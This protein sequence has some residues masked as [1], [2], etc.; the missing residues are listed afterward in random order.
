MASNRNIRNISAVFKKYV[1]MDISNSDVRVI[2]VRGNQVRKWMTSPLPEGAV[3]DGMIIE[4]HTVSVIIDNVF[5]SLNLNKNNVLCSL[6][7]LPFIY[8]VISMPRDEHAISDEAIERAARQEMS[9]AQEDIH[10]LWQA[11]E[12]NP[13]NMEMDYF[14]LGVPRNYIKPLEDTIY[15][16]GIKPYIVDVKPLA[17]ARAAS[18]RDGLIVS[19]EKS[20]YDIVLVSNGLVRVMHSFS[21]GS[22]PVDK[23]S[24]VNDVIDGLNKA[25]KSFN[26]DFPENTLDPDIPLLLAGETAADSEIVA[27]MQEATGHPV[28]ILNPVLEVPAEMPREIYSAA[29]GLV[30]KKIKP[31]V[32]NLQYRDIDINLLMKSKKGS[33]LRYQLAY[34]GLGVF[35]LLLAFLVYEAFQYKSDAA[36]RTE[37]LQAE[38]V[39]STQLLADIRKVNTQALADKQTSTDQLQSMTARLSAV[40]ANREQI[41]NQKRDYA[42]GFDTINSSL[43]TGSDY[44]NITMQ[45]DVIRVKGQ[46][47]EPFE[48]L[49]FTDALERT[50]TFSS[51]II[52]SINP[53]EGSAGA[54]FDI[55]ITR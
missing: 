2:S 16:A 33:Q 7:G 6:T 32:D 50:G 39:R 35:F 53:I 55:I 22:K 5:K 54:N 36:A 43:P 51:V 37:A 42:G 26:R 20:Y 28:S 25:I 10:L 34:A 4:P 13:D 29:L 19:L 21:P 40:T 14:V 23:I 46:V 24:T 12:P 38:Q 41:L 17:L 47:T 45:P 48:I 9:L 52:D 31:A 15:R 30:A 27:L 3:K 1:A 18:I 11:T 8:R 49:D 44:E